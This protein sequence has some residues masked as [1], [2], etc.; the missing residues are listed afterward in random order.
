MDWISLRCNFSR[1][2]FFFDGRG[3]AHKCFPW[4]GMACYTAQAELFARPAPFFVIG[5]FSQCFYA[6]L[7]LPFTSFRSSNIRSTFVGG[8][9]TTA[10]YSPIRHSL[11][12]RATLWLVFRNFF[13]LNKNLTISL[14]GRQCRRLRSPES[15]S[16][17]FAG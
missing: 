6:K 14:V 7:L 17:R 3:L 8:D 2:E 5:L 9:F 10:E 1:A 12:L 13:H 15:A 11:V 16:A 4:K